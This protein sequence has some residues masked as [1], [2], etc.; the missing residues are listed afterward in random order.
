MAQLVNPDCLDHES[1]LECHGVIDMD[2]SAVL[3]RV[4]LGQANIRRRIGH[5]FAETLVVDIL[6]VPTLNQREKTTV[7][8]AIA[9]AFGLSA[10]P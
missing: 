4:D 3:D 5:A 9:S 1:F 2:M 8:T 10:K 7:A 6:M